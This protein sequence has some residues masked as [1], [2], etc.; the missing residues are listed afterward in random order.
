[1]TP[2]CQAVQRGSIPGEPLGHEPAGF[3]QTPEVLAA[4][5]GFCPDEEKYKELQGRVGTLAIP[6]RMRD[7][8]HAVL[9][10][11]RSF[12]SGIEGTISGHADLSAAG[13]GGLPGRLRPGPAVRRP[14]AS[15]R[16]GDL[17]PAGP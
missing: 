12:R 2:H 6:R 8:A 14:A 17:H 3:G 13:R 16:A 5:M 10:M 9:S 1:M 7:L 15:V 4:D 11:W